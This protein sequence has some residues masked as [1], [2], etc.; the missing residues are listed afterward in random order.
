MSTTIYDHCVESGS[1][2]LA[3]KRLVSWL[4]KYN[5]ILRTNGLTDGGDISHKIWGRNKK[6]W[7][8]FKQVDDEKM[9]WNWLSEVKSISKSNWWLSESRWPV[10]CAINIAASSVHDSKGL[11][12]LQWFCC[13][14]HSALHCSKNRKNQFIAMHCISCW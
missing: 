5:H 3:G 11:F 9:K 13:K 1:K 4:S 2:I 12:R 6:N 14:Q 10:N 8:L 7:K